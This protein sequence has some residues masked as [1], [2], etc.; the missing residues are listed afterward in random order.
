MSS[1]VPRCQSVKI[2]EGKHFN[3]ITGGTMRRCRTSGLWLLLLSSLVFGGCYGARV[4]ND[5]SGL[6]GYDIKATSDLDRSVVN[7]V[8]RVAL[9]APTVK[10]HPDQ[11][12]WI[13]VSPVTPTAETDTTPPP[14]L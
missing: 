13:S 12:S 7:S 9:A 1:T 4:N 10:A 3:W 2:V 11:Y 5:R 14:C 8:V 6:G